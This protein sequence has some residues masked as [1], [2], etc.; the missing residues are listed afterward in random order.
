LDVEVKRVI[1]PLESF[2][3]LRKHLQ[4]ELARR[5]VAETQSLRESET[6][7]RIKLERCSQEFR[8]KGCEEQRI[9][10]ADQSTATVAFQFALHS[11]I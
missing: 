2:H 10:G 6:N 5:L 4:R 11:L 7:I 1:D 3:L 9:T 8:R